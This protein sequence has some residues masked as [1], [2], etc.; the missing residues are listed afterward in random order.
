[1]KCRI[2][3][4]C[5]AILLTISGLK[6][7]EKKSFRQQIDQYREA[8]KTSPNNPELLFKLAQFLSWDGQYDES[9]K[10]YEKL[11]DDNPQNVDALLGLASVFSWKQL[12]DKSIEVN[13][14]ILQLEPRNREALFNMGK[15]FFWKGDF[16]TARKY[17][18]AVLKINPQDGEVVQALAKLDE[19]AS[20]S[21]AEYASKNLNDL[22]KALQN[23]PNDPDLHVA[24]AQRYIAR[25]EY[26]KA[27][28]HLE[29]AHTVAPQKLDIMILL[30]RIYSWDQQYQKSIQYYD[31][32]LEKDPK[33]IE[34][35]LGKGQ[36]YSWTDRSNEAVALLKKL[37]KE[38]PENSEALISLGRVYGWKGNYEESIGAWRQVLKKDPK[39]I[40]ALKGL[41]NTYKWAKQYAQ[42]IATE[43]KILSYYPNEV[44]SMLSMGYMYVEMGALDKSI[45]WYE[46]ASTIEPHRS[47]IHAF[48]GILYS[49]AA[50]IDDAATAL[51]K[52]IELQEGNISSYV[53]LGRVYGW[54]AKIKEAKKLYETALKLDPYNIEA[55]NGYAQVHYFDGEWNKAIEIYGKSLKTK[56]KNIEGLEG[57]KQVKRA[58]APVFESRLNNFYT[59]DFDADPSQK[60]NRLIY[61]TRQYSQEFTYKWAPNLNVQGRYQYNNEQRKDLQASIDYDLDEHVAS[62]RGEVPVPYLKGAS[63][64]GRGE[65]NE[66]SNSD[67]VASFPLMQTE[68]VFTG[69]GIFKYQKD[70]IDFIAASTKELDI[71]ISGNTRVEYLNN[72]GASLT[73]DLTKHLS[74]IGSYFYTDRKRI[75]GLNRSDWRGIVNYRL[76]FWEKMELGYEYRYRN[77]L[78]QRTQ[79]VTARFQDRFLK[80]LLVD[81][82]LRL[83][84]DD[85]D[86][87]FGAKTTTLD[88]RGFLSWEVTPY[89]YLSTDLNHSRNYGDDKDK[90]FNA[91]FYLTFLLD[92]LN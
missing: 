73:Y 23:N 55:L 4:L 8:L 68:Q 1:M 27:L 58:K 39:N 30:A 13:K 86:G 10:I 29:K 47:D 31:L 14:K 82:S 71:I 32:V 41:A 49:Y 53:A 3:S 28:E 80:K 11:I 34:A 76:P 16:E 70:K 43:Q 66:V 91:R 54:Q 6:A 63:L 62:L 36:V 19:I 12:Y 9:I 79:S 81:L 5:I 18:E 84:R 26:K 25:T 65:W 24:L 7:D 57:L 52:S 37:L 35:Q 89:I 78:P 2:L 56:P 60:V 15:V 48:L 22:E 83:D 72:H 38:H 64:I 51:K 90:T 17:Y 75:A 20:Q 88:Y 59:K 42:G 87:N 74:L 44:E 45:F 85:N 21:G 77:H 67:K 92:F 40:E 61:N 69:F 33:N 50:R 46:K